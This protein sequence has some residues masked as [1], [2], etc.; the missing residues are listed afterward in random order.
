MNFEFV[1]AEKFMESISVYIV[2]WAAIFLGG[3][4]LLWLSW[5]QIRVAMES[6]RF[7]GAW[8]IEFSVSRTGDPRVFWIQMAFLILIGLV[9]IAICSWSAY[10]V[11]ILILYND[12]R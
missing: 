3:I 10:S 12:M 6:G 1:S 8:G 5:L 2:K 9:G 11:I 7:F 4:F